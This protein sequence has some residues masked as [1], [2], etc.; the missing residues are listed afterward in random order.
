MVLFIIHLEIGK[1]KLALFWNGY[2]VKATTLSHSVY[3]YI[4]VSVQNCNNSSALSLQLQ[5]SCAKPYINLTLSNK[6]Q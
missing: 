1:Y 2:V 3:Q 6:L 5:Q 4:D